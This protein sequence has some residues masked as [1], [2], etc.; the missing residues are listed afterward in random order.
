MG[1]LEE[2]NIDIKEVARKFNT[3]VEFIEWKDE[4]G[5]IRVFEDE[6]ECFIWIYITDND[7]SELVET[8]ISLADKKT[9]EF[10]SGTIG[11]EMIKDKTIK[12]DDGRIVFIFGCSV[13]N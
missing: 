6:K 9:Y 11:S 8:L 7:K 10:K 3:T 1:I 12:L 13:D 4:D 2:L 5:E